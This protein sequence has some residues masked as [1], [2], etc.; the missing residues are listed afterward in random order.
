MNEDSGDDGKNR[1][2][3]AAGSAVA[4]LEKVGQSGNAG[5]DIEGSEE[6]CRNDERER[7]H[8]LEV[9]VGQPVDVA[10][11]SKRDQVNGRDIGRE[12]SQSDDRPRQGAAG[13][14]VVL[15]SALP[16]VSPQPHPAAKAH[17]A[18]QINN[19]DDQV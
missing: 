2:P 16:L 12:Q 9:A 17:D 1:Q 5:T 4:L 10:F 13:Q 18:Q 11:L 6:Q 19:D 3:V 7:R 14:K 15:P 8:P